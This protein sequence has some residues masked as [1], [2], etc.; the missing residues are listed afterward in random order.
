MVIADKKGWVKILEATIAVLIVSGVLVVVY[1]EQTDK[2]IIG[3]EDYIHSLQ[4][5]ILMDISSR[6]D[7][8]NYV[9]SE[10]ISALKNYTSGKIP[11]AFN[12]SLKICNLTSPPSPCKMDSADFIATKEKNVY[13][14]ETI[15]SAD[16]TEG[17]NPK[18]VRIFIWENG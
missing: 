7:L 18:K 9:L 15:I 4:K 16:F 8:R 12:Y 1:S 5:Q 10:N 2:E 14:E 13:V 17:Y 3:P 11:P 6:N